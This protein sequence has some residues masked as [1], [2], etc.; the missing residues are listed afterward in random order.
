M[1]CL[2]GASQQQVAYIFCV[3]QQSVG[4]WLRQ[5]T[6]AALNFEMDTA[7]QKA[8]PA[9]IKELF[10]LS[11]LI[12]QHSQDRGRGKPSGFLQRYR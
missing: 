12:L 9:W 8:Y 11:A 1:M 2:E 5:V 3:S 6:T 4:N 10:P 7:V